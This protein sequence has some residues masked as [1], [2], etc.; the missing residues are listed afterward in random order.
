MFWSNFLRLCNERKKSPT[1]V[2]TELKISRGSVT[3]W[4]NGKTPHATTIQKIA[5][6]FDVPV[7]RLLGKE[8]AVSENKN[9]ADYMVFL[10]YQNADD[11]T[12]K[13]IRKLLDLEEPANQEKVLDLKSELQID[14]SKAFTKTTT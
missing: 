1:S 13:A 12:R 10:A 9:S 5:D 14:V 2:I 4:K 11:S 3:N 6:Y 8:N 7:D